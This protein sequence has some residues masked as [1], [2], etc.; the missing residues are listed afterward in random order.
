MSTFLEKIKKLEPPKEKRFLHTLYDGFFTFLY[1][2]DHT[3]KGP[4]VHILDRM[5][6]KRTMVMVVLALQLCYVFGTYNIGHQH[7][8]ALGM[9]TSFMAGLHLKLAYGLIKLL[10]LFVVS[11]VVG[12][13]IEFFYAA[14]KGHG[15]EEGYLVTGALIPLIMPPDIPLWILSLSI[16]FAV[17]LGKEAFGGTGM[18]I[19][20]IALLSR[21]FV[22]FAYPTTISGDQCWVAGLEYAG[23]KGVGETYGWAQHFFDWIFNGLGWATFGEGGR[24]IADAFTGATP[25]GLASQG[26]EQVTAVYSPM[27]MFWGVIPGSIGETSKPLIIVGALML[28]ATGIASWRIMLSCLVGAVFMAMAFNWWGFDAF[29][30]VPWYYHFYM[31]SFWFAVAFMA[32]DPV[33]ASS[34]NTGKWIYGFSIGA[35]GIIIRI[36]NPAYPEGWM[37]AILF[38]NVFAPLIDHFVVESNIKR[39]QKISAAAGN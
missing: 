3:T 29:M 26:W 37:L 24:A 6:L 10:P 15:I 21:V 20:N 27:Q 19:V 4:G 36:M 17:I 32:T 13:G 39:R 18:N 14:K 25:L 5:D 30:N 22:F 2:P 33:T 7:F 9:H 34:T 28:I 35:L 16:A 1:V 11:M 23:G 38:M 12:L 31:G 8:V